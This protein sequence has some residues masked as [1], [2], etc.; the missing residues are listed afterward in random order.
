MTPKRRVPLYRIGIFYCCPSSLD[1]GE[2]VFFPF[3]VSILLSPIFLFLWL[4]RFNCR[5]FTGQV[6]G[7]K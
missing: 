7:Y 3:R 6:A 1:D 4:L 2:S 5:L